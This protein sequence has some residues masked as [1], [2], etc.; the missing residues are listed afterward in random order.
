MS[1]LIVSNARVNSALRRAVYRHGGD[2][3]LQTPVNVR[4]LVERISGFQARSR[5]VW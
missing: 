1:W 4:D 2:A 3:L 5:P